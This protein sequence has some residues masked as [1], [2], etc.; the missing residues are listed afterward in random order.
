MQCGCAR[1]TGPLRMIQGEKGERCA[2]QDTRKQDWRRSDLG[3]IDALLY[4]V[5]N[6]PGRSAVE[7]SQAIYG[8]QSVSCAFNKTLSGSSA[9][10][11]SSGAA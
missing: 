11:R 8:A 9:P 10:A 5:E 6:G 3:Q 2:D 1:L 7:L 4:L